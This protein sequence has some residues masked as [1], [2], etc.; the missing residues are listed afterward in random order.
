MSINEKIKRLLNLYKTYS[1]SNERKQLSN[2]NRRIF[3]MKNFTANGIISYIQSMNPSFKNIP[4]RLPK[5]PV[6][7]QVN[8]R[9]Q[10]ANNYMR[11]YGTVLNDINR[12]FLNK[13]G[14][15]NDPYRRNKLNV[16]YARNRLPVF[17]IGRHIQ[18]PYELSNI[19]Y[20]TRLYFGN[21]KNGMIRRKLMSKNVLKNIL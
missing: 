21:N 14:S 9:K 17:T 11:K 20:T 18:D 6:Q 16:I 19:I 5:K 10:S 8:K 15:L 13:Y 2:V 12:A 3:G 1:Y 4:R 7:V